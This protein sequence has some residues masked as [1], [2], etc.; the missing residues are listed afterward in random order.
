[1]R[2]FAELEKFVSE[3]HEEL[4][5]R[6][7]D[8]YEFARK[9]LKQRKLNKSSVLLHKIGYCHS[10]MA[11]PDSIKQWGLEERGEEDAEKWH[12]DLSSFIRGRIIVPIYNE[13]GKLVA[14][15]T[16]PP[17]LSKGQTW[18]NLPFP[19]SDNIYMLN[20]A[21]Q[22]IFESNKIYLVE[23]YMDALILFQAGLKNVCCIMGTALTSRQIGLIARYCNNI[24][25]C[26]DLDQNESGQK[27]EAKS[28]YI[29]SEFG[30]C[31]K[32]SKIQGLQIGQDPDM[33]INENGLEAFLNLEHILNKAEIQ[34]VCKKV[35]KDF[36]Y[37]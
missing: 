17:N 29:V 30:F 35:R 34:S 32:I 26:F 12:Y 2:D 20:H 9:Y 8:E 3:C 22:S 11:I 16:R 7:R 36:M 13:F 24:C 10:K 27:A 19:K 4:L 31:D 14:F 1:M 15:A 33:F 37:G 6:Q 21:R 5:F 25:L 23:G 18:W 28:I